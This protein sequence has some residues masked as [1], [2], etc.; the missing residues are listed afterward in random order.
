ME[1]EKTV[2]HFYNPRISWT[3]FFCVF[4]DAGSQRLPWSNNKNA[5][6]MSSMLN[7]SN[8]KLMLWQSSCFCSVLKTTRSQFSHKLSSSIFWTFLKEHL[9]FRA[10]GFTCC[11]KSLLLKCGHVLVIMN[12]Q[13]RSEWAEMIDSCFQTLVFNTFFSTQDAV[14]TQKGHIIH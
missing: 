8:D 14:S 7:M 5:I 3:F 10:P 11:L 13:R 4:G 2:R 6:L 9:I 1:R 12:V